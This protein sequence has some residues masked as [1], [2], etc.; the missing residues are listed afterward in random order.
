MYGD[1][2]EALEEHIL[3]KLPDTVEIYFIDHR[4]TQSLVTFELNRW[5][6]R[7]NFVYVFAYNTSMTDVLCKAK[8][9]KALWLAD[10]QSID[11]ISPLFMKFSRIG[12]LSVLFD[13]HVTI[14]P[15]RFKSWI[16]S[17]EELDLYPGEVKFF[18]LIN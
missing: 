13:D 16:K 5:I 3:R 8:T 11:E 17:I 4:T 15:S 12:C 2:S 14:K 6:Q 18:I 9:L 1:R 10:V 7:Y